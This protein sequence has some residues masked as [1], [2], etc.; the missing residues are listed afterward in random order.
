[1]DPSEVYP[2]LLGQAVSHSAQ[3]VAQ[4]G[5]LLASWAVVEARR[6]ERRNAAKQARSEHELAM[7]REQEQA[8]RK[9]ARAGWAPALDRT[10]LAEAD[11]L[12]TAR[13][14]S[15]AASY[16]DADPEAA[17]AAASSE[18]RLRTLHPYAMARYDRLRAEGAGRFEA[19]GETVPLFARARHARPGDPGPERP[20]LGESAAPQTA[21]LAIE[22]PEDLGQ[23]RPGPD[24]VT[25]EEQ[26]GQ[27][28]VAR[29]QARAAEERGAA[30]SPDELA[31]VLGATTTLPSD[32]IA[33]LARGEAQERMAAGAERERAFDLDQAPVAHVR[34]GGEGAGYLEQ[35][36]REKLTADTA[37]A[38]AAGD[39]SAA[40]LAAESFPCS[41]SDAVGAAR[42]ATADSGQARPR[43][44]PVQNVRRP[45][46]SL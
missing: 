27:Q 38:H 3:R 35:A 30:L 2:D 17:A 40:H 41:A 12:G 11:L 14:W 5:S 4:M 46:L 28:I 34:P 33:R 1:M 32:V 39:K 29:L 44:L 24:P 15:A 8:A 6:T 20:H 45:G 43:T 25:P 13:V 9:L 7:L 26:R 21:P 23:P 36:G 42:T 18:E 22:A 16:A 10:W 37:T 19:M 31:T